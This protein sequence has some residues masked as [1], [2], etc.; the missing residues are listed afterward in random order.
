[1]VSSEVKQPAVLAS[2]MNRCGSRWYRIPSSF[3]RS[4][5][6][7]RTATV[8]TSAPDASIAASM[9]AL[10]A[11][12]P[13][14]TMRRE[15]NSRPPISNLVS[16]AVVRSSAAVISAAAN[17]MHDLEDVAVHQDERR[18]RV[19]VPQDRAVVLDHDETRIELQR[20]EEVGEGGARRD[21][22]RV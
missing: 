7:R 12:F 19:A 2:S 17:E 16:S 3:V 13:V 6:T 18:V 1:M 4:R 20:G 8:T 11:Y 15:R 9:W 14:P 5:S 10:E 21:R 22:S